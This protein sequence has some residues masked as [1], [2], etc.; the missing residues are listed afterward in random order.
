MDVLKR[1]S[2]QKKPTASIREI[3]PAGQTQPP[4]AGAETPNITPVTDE[5]PT[6][7][8]IAGN[9]TFYTHLAGGQMRL[10]EI[11]PGEYP[12]PVSC[13]LLRVDASGPNISYVALS[14]CW[15]DGKEVERVQIDGQQFAISAHLYQGLRRMRSSR[16]SQYIWV[17]AICINQ[18]DDDEKSQQVQQMGAIYDRAQRTIIWLGETGAQQPT[19]R[20]DKTG[21]CTRLELSAF[22][23]P[24]AVPTMRRKFE[25]DETYSRQDA[26][27]MRVWWKRL[28]VI[29]EFAAS[30]SDP[31]VLVGPH[32]ISWDSF[33]ELRWGKQ[34]DRRPLFLRLRA[35]RTKD[36]PFAR[37]PLYDLLWDTVVDFECEQPRDKIYALL[38]LVD[39]SEKPLE[40]D[41]RKPCELVYAEAAVYLIKKH[42]TVDVLLDKTPRLARGGVA[43][44]IPRWRSMQPKWYGKAMDGY[45]ACSYPPDVKL[46][47]RR[48]RSR[49]GLGTQPVKSS[50]CL[51][52]G[53]AHL[54][55]RCLQFDRIAIRHKW[56]VPSG[57][58]IRW[59]DSGDVMFKRDPHG[60]PKE[61]YRKS[62]RRRRM[63]RPVITE[64]LRST[65]LEKDLREEL[66]NELWT[67]RELLKAL[68][69]D[70]HTKNR[71]DLDRYPHMGYLMLEYIFNGSRRLID[72][73]D[74]VPEHPSPHAQKAKETAQMLGLAKN[75]A[76]L[77]DLEVAFSWEEVFQLKTLYFETSQKSQLELLHGGSRYTVPIEGAT[78][79]LFSTE[80]GFTGL[81]PAQVEPGDEVVVPFGSSRPWVLRNH[82]DH[83]VFVGDAVVPGIM[84]G[85]LQNLYED[86]LVDAEDYTLR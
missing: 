85:R 56:E 52:M 14:Y 24:L 10:L 40:I 38:G 68:K 61:T 45:S 34:S 18:A 25:T 79:V 41:Y 39:D 63:V 60:I 5:K 42:Q 28:W 31:L 19:C 35:G 83:H 80:G 64:H 72:M 2:R 11:C 29:Q 8:S 71:L 17:D 43:L 62:E 27:W 74:D 1:L 65:Q 50:P 6:A 70:A 77:R 36:Y 73:F 37:Q 23:H 3:K 75:E 33:A 78:R 66:K 4:Q 46:D 67:P 86:G 47:F 12:E 21:V 76:V 53:R 48:I 32:A 49:K 58:A 82:G 44:W 20:R 69:F 16:A 54:T 13:S 57:F 7:P 55:L 15:G 59:D 26:S 84:S 81:G 30:R 51:C 22:E 9:T